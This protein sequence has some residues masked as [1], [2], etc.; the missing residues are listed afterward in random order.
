[1]KSKLLISAASAALIGISGIAFAQSPSQQSPGG[2]M[3]GS[4]SA[5]GSEGAS[6]GQMAPREG[7]A[8]QRAQDQSPGMKGAKDK[9][10]S[11]NMRGN[12]N[13]AESDSKNSNSKAASEKSRMDSNKAASDTKSESKSGMTT[14]QAGAG[15]KQLTS[16][17]RTSIH[18]S[19]TK[20][21]VRPVTNVNFSISVGTRV[22]RGVAFHQLPVEV[23][24]IYPD[25]RGYEF[26]LVNDQ[27][28]VVNPRT[29]K[30]V[31][32]LDA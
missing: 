10:A 3:Q 20:L 18:T 24:N 5:R 16:E 31:A 32:V 9:A 23:V 12:K 4:G 21:N 2:A 28:V 1:M 29:L 27:I 13:A 14:G 19:I 6:G 17:Q 7:A 25:W 30:I 15:G 11:D 26:I 8:E 22:P